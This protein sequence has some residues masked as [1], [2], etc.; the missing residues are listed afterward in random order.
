MHEPP[1]MEK[2][3]GAPSQQR[4]SH[5]KAHPQYGGRRQNALPSQKAY[6]EN[7]DNM[8]QIE[9]QLL[10]LQLEKDKVR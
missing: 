6:A 5:G 8:K 2:A 10:N 3:Y 9:T 1:P 7:Q 4:P